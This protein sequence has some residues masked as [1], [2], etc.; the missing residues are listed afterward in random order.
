MSGEVADVTDS[1]KLPCKMGRELIPCEQL[2]DLVYQV[3]IVDSFLVQDEHLKAPAAESGA[4]LRGNRQ[5]VVSLPEVR[6][7]WLRH[8]CWYPTELVS[9]P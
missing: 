1:I 4:C 3:S 7:Q 9:W 5:R 2:L 6:S 8:S